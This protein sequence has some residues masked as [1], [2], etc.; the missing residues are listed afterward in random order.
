MSLPGD[1]GEDE[2]VGKVD[3]DQGDDAGGALLAGLGEREE[4]AKE[5]EDAAGGS[6][7]ADVCCV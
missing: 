5:A 6:Q 3:G 7:G 2:A 1:V 4:G